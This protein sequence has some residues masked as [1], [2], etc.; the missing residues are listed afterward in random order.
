MVPMT[1]TE[2]TTTSLLLDAKS[3][4]GLILGTALGCGLMAGVFFAFST[5]VM[6]GL[7][8]LSP[9][10]GI[11]A[12]QSINVTAVRP[13]FM[14]LLFGT[15]VGC[16]ALIIISVRAWGDRGSSLLLLAGLLYLIG[17]IGLTVAYHVPLNDT[18]AAVDP[19]SAGAA[20]EWHH[21]V[22]H[23]TGWNHVRTGSSLAAAATLT[24]TLLRT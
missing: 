15:A 21:Y 14:T 17:V 24:L 16:V 10:Q 12:M 11:S 20:A 6:S 8:R 3:V 22:G 18:L 4:Q 7:A 23:W 5:F 13:A 1:T 9:A 19:N 2:P